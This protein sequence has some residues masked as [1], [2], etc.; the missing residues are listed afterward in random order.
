ME[1]IYQSFKKTPKANRI[2]LGD[3]N[4]DI[5]RPKGER[6]MEI[7][8]LMTNLGLKDSSWHFCQKLKHQKGFTW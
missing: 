3:I 1:L 4:V 7:A 2:F 6:G 8:T 5:V